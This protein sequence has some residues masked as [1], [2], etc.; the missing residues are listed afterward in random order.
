[1]RGYAALERR[2]HELLY[3]FFELTTTCN[4]ACLHC[5]S[6]CTSIPRKKQIDTQSWIRIARYVR[7]KFPKVSVVLTGG[8]PLTHPDINEITKS[9]KDNGLRWGIVTNGTLIS[10]ERLRC[11]VDNGIYSLTVS[12][13]GPPEIHDWLRNKD[14]AF[15]MVLSSLKHIRSYPISHADVVTC[16][17]PRALD[18][19][20]EIAD[21]VLEAGIGIWRLFKIFPAGRARDN[22]DLLLDNA[23]TWKLLRWVRDNRAKYRARGLEIT[24]ACEGWIP[25]RFSRQIRDPLSMCRAGI[26]IA[27]I[28]SDGTVTGCPN[29]DPSFFVGNI[30]SDDLEE[31]WENGFNRLRK[32]EWLKDSQCGSCMYVSNCR[33]GSLHLWRGG[34]LSFCYMDTS[35]KRSIR[36]HR[37]TCYLR[38]NAI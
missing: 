29:N 17:T 34:D 16:V 37:G 24:Y 12:L 10:A 7:Q 8:E 20:E 31:L 32:R 28:L 19:I 6:D 11:L 22:K 1:M 18:R 5:G 23:Q 33:G 21:I 9:L 2:K 30:V 3:L 27:S 4:L 36:S 13:D 38:K 14:G 15:N 25:Q 35:T 26:Q